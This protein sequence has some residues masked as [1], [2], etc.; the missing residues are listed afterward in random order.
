LTKKKWLMSIGAAVVA[1]M[2]VFGGAQ[3]ASAHAAGNSYWGVVC[4]EGHCIPSGTMLHVVDGNGI[5]LA[6]DRV[7]ITSIS[8]TCNWWVDFDYYDNAGQ[9]YRHVQG[10]T[11][12]GCTNESHVRI[13]YGVGPYL[14][15]PG[16]ACATL[17]SSAVQLT[18]Q[19]HYIFP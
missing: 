16:R 14:W 12:N 9:R 13:D 11:H 18:R 2:M 1:L 4:F 7:E 3:S 5:Q 19:C 10:Q 15:K 6:Y 8:N 17:Y